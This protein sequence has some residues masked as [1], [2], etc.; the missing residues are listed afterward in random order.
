MPL[1][2][3]FCLQMWM[4]QCAARQ[5]RIAEIN[6]M[7]TLR[8]ATDLTAVV[9]MDHVQ[10]KQPGYTTVPGE[11]EAFTQH[12][13]APAAPEKALW[14]YSLAAL[15]IA[16]VLGLY[17][18]F[19]T[20]ITQ[21]IRACAAVLLIALPATAHISMSRPMA[22]V[23]KRLH[24]LDAV[25]CGWHGIRYAEKQAVY[26]VSGEDLF[27]EN[28]IKM[29]GVKF[30]GS[31][32]PGWVTSS[33]VALLAAN[34]SCMQRLFEQLP[35]G[36]DGLNQLVEEMTVC[37]GGI[38]GLVS[39][40][41]TLL[42]TAEFMEQMAV[43]IPQN[44]HIPGAVYV[45]VD[46]ELSGVYAVSYGCDKA[47]AAG[48]RNLCTWRSLS[49]VLVSSDFLL[50]PRFIRE[51]L[52]VKPRRMAFP[53][54]AVRQTL[55]Q[56]QPAEDAPVLALIT[57][58]GLAAKTCALNSAWVLRS[59]MS[60]GANIHLLGGIMGLLLAAVMIILLAFEML[61]PTNLLL[62]TLIWMVPGW[63]VT[64]WTRYIS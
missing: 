20:D 12:Y 38:S 16:V 10:E 3:L 1:S 36:R 60:A 32:D 24:N 58:P 55:S 41:P 53:D 52:G 34:G 44:A 30:Y 7:D 37:D 49:P 17:A 56:M 29:N 33:A 15:A 46:G 13:A 50:S 61:S 39:G 31:V 14:K 22:I 57:K 27:P 40:V 26:P 35:R 47:A 54:R 64:E 51:T 11:P 28:T 63:L 25:L 9:R 4:A 23:Q 5:Q 18:G 6:Q 62:Y 21:G 43:E 59:A 8:K 48:L 19:Q 45:V 42:G 2:G